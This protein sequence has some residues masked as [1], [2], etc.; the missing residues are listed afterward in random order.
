MT[1]NVL[2]IF[3]IL[4]LPEKMA[5]FLRNYILNMKLI[6]N[7]THLILKKLRNHAI[8]ICDIKKHYFG[9]IQCNS[10]NSTRFIIDFK[11]QSDL[12]F[13]YSHFCGHI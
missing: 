8:E 5:R 9:H 7:K 10:K 3:P 12:I 2:L 4:L 13:K 1:K 6:L 11:M